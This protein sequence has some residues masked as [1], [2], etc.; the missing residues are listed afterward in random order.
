MSQLGS[1]TYEH[2]PNV[3][4]HRGFNGAAVQK[5]PTAERCVQ[6]ENPFR[7][8][9]YPFVRRSLIVLNSRADRRRCLVSGREGRDSHESGAPFQA[10][11]EV[12]DGLADVAFHEVPAGGFAG[13]QECGGVLDAVRGSVPGVITDVG[14]ARCVRR[15]VRSIG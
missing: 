2:Y 6:L 3:G 9:R 10:C 13:G 11:G 5:G 7:S 4:A 14:P 12:V 1:I 15:V 8:V